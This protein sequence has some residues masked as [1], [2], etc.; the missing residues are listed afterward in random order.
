MRQRVTGQTADT[1]FQ[2][3]A[4]KTF[5]ILPK[6]AW[7]LITKSK[8]RNIW[9]GKISR[10]S[11]KKG[12]NYETE[13]GT[14]GEIRSINTEKLIRLTWKPHNWQKSSTVQIRIIP[15]GKNTSIRIHQEKLPNAEMR[16]QMKKHWQEVLQHFQ[17]IVEK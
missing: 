13:N 16:K 10:M 5:P 9:L 1:G 6:Q 17:E 8:G 7:E 15:S 11:F 4:Q 14:S 3:G 12:Y 2:I